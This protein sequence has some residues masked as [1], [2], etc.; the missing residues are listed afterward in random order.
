MSKRITQQHI[1]DALQLSRNTV[2]KALNN[3]E[4]LKEETRVRIVKQAIQMGY[5]KFPPGLLE[6]ISKLS[7]HREPTPDPNKSRLIA[8]LS[9]SDYMGNYYWSQFLSG[10]NSSL[11]EAGYTV[12]MAIVDL[13]EENELRLPPLFSMQRPAGMITIG[14]FL[15]S[16]YEHLEQ[17]G[18]PA[19]FVDTFATF[20][21]N[22]L[23][24]DIL[25]MNNSDSVYQ[26]T[27]SILANGYTSIGFVGDIG[28]CLSYWE[29]WMGFNRAME[30]AK[31]PMNEVLNITNTLPRHY[32]YKEQL[33][34]ALRENQERP[35]VYICAN[36]AVAIELVHLL[37]EEGKRVPED[38]LVTGFDNSGELSL[39]QPSMPTVDVPKREMGLRA[40]ELL[41]WRI[42]H[43][44][45]PKEFVRVATRVIGLNNLM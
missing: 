32:Y 42:D 7:E 28:S 6:S 23:K 31:L 24:T 9:H 29:R 45:R 13:D 44:D 17:T 2:S 21:M 4:G 27:K 41:K 14:S 20:N 25:T 15:Q 12:A 10:L 1:A 8:L 26:M 35:Q 19:L 3:E 36:D 39:L 37:R 34:D 11:K 40:A 22:E 16:Y 5:T 30:E 38:I 43:P 33:R 18:I